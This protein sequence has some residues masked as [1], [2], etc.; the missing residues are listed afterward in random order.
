MSSLKTIHVGRKQLGLAEED[1]RDL[2]QRVTGK[3]SSADMNEQQRQAVIGEM[4]GLG[5]AATPSA[6]KKSP[7][8]HV[9]KVFAL[10]SEAGRCGAVESASRQSLVSFVQGLTEIGDPNWLD[11]AQAN[12]VIEALKAMNRRAGAAPYKG[13][14]R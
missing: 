10:W 3:R 6:V 4:R 9:R 8:A 13:R 5:F 2:L 12:K 14:R 7:H 1:Y 11:A